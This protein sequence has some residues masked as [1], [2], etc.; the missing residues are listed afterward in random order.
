MFL[1][2]YAVALALKKAAPKT[3]LGVLVLAAQFIDFLWPLF[4]LLGLEHVRIDPG[5]T[6]FTPLDFHDYPF[7]H[8]L[9]AVLAWASGFGAIY[10]LLRRNVRS[11]IILGACVLS[12][13]LLDAL[14]HRPDLPL[15]PS[16]TTRVGF[17]LWNHLAATIVFEGALFAIGIFW[18]ARA[19]MA[20][21]RIGRV[22]FWGLMILLGGI[23]CA[24]IFS[25]PPPN[26]TAVALAGLSLW[27]TAAW[28]HWFDQ[29]RKVR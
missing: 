21:D 18:Y 29:H 5:N 13:W 11:A 28:A 20:V 17:G 10:F 23:W 27:L 2:H 22:A 4:L 15:G 26:S 7:S 14:T 1:G 12:H 16:G 6:V 24:N 9:L 8:S 19:T 25:P 3:S